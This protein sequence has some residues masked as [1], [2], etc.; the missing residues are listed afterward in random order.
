M[1]LRKT[2]IIR[3][4]SNHKLLILLLFNNNNHFDFP[5]I[6]FETCSQSR[7]ERKVG[8]NSE[9]SFAGARIIEK[10]LFGLGKKTGP[11]ITGRYP[12]P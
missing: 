1:F 3:V 4:N 12:L 6:G 2:Q 9:N 5:C 11:L 7:R 8:G 10:V